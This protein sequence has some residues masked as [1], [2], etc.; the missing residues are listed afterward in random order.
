[1]H[2]DQPAWLCLCVPLPP[3]DR[4]ADSRWAACWRFCFTLADTDPTYERPFPPQQYDF[5]SLEH[6]HSGSASPSPNLRPVL[7][8][9]YQQQPWVMVVMMMEV[10]DH[11]AWATGNREYYGNVYLRLRVRFRC[12]MLDAEVVLTDSLNS[13]QHIAL[14]S[15]YL[16]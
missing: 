2:R 3:M 5:W 15:V 9:N 10:S 4:A 1:M 14:I 13:L 11:E 7:S 12:R 8:C 6:W 16:V